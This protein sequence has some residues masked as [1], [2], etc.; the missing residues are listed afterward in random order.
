MTGEY[1]VHI[2]NCSHALFY[3]EN[4]NCSLLMLMMLFAFTSARP[5]SVIIFTGLWEQNSSRERLQFI[6]SHFQ[7]GSNW[8]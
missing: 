1:G 3:A 6:K 2:L 7:S 5:W 4:V 8:P